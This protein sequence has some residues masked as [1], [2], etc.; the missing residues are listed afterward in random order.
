[1]NL[2]AV[3]IHWFSY[4]LGLCVCRVTGGSPLEY[5]C[6]QVLLRS[7]FSYHLSDFLLVVGQAIV[8][9]EH[10]VNVSHGSLWCEAKVFMVMWVFP[11]EAN[12]P[13]DPDGDGFTPVDGECDDLQQNSIQEPR[14]FTT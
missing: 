6:D 8:N 12:A 13:C 4:H 7:R 2:R 1:M 3:V 5:L 10:A 14:R 11:S 9:G